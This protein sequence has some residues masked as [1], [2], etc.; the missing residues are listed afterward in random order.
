MVV[1]PIGK[2]DPLGNPAVCVMTNPAQLSLAAG[3]GQNTIA[4][5]L[6]GVLFTLMFTG[7]DVNTGTWLSVT[8][9]VKVHVLVFPLASVAVNVLVVIPIGNDEPDGNPVVCVNVIP[10]QL[11]FAAGATQVTTA[12]QVP[13]V[14]LTETLTGHEVNTGNWLSITVTV[15]EH[16]AVFP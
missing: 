2:F 3:A 8:V 15:N 7:H 6:P 1:T 16:K 10:E 12:E 14:L 5:Q 13:G 9:T 11:S 4:P